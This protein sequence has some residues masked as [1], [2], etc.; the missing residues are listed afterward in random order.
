VTLLDID[1]QMLGIA[2]SRLA[3]H[4]RRTRFLHASFHDPLPTFDVAVASLS[5][6]HVQDRGT[7]LKVYSSLRAALRPGGMFATCDAMVSADETVRARTMKRWSEHL[8]RG[9]DTEAEAY[10][11]FADWAKEER[12]FAVEEELAAMH[13]AGFARVEVAWRRG[14]LALLLGFSE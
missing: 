9:G 10:A 11:R 7:K 2:E 6:H 14:P 1:A 4:A 12:Y 13:T 3:N 5:L 8:V